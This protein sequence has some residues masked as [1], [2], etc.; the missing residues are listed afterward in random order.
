MKRCEKC[1]GENEDF[2]NYC[3]YCGAAFSERSAEETKPQERATL[4][5]IVENDTPFNTQALKKFYKAL[6]VCAIV[7][8]VCGAFALACGL[9][10]FLLDAEKTDVSLFVMGAA[11]LALGIVLLFLYKKSTTGNKTITENTHQLYRFREDGVV[12]ETYE[13]ETKTSE[14][15]VRYEQISR[16]KCAKTLIYIYFGNL[17][18]LMNRDTYV[19]GSEWEL[20]SLLVSKGV[21]GAK[22]I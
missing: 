5:S 18:W 10:I 13:G 9:I 15:S 4:S 21:K 14:Q 22:K 7:V 16:V 11:C 1:G 20:K 19:L 6:F 8:L 17:V 12:A 2:A 3:K